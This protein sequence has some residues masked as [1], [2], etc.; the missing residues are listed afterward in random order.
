MWFNQKRYF[1]IV[2]AL[3]VMLV[4][5]YV[6]G[7]FVDVTRDAGKYASVAREVYE[8][9]D[10][11][12][13]RVHGEPYDQKPPM[14]FWLSALSFYIFGLS[15]F[16]FK[17]PL[18]FTGLLGIYSTYRLGK[19]L[20][21]VR[22]GMTAAMMLAA[23]QVYFLYYMDIHTDSVLQPFVTFALWQLYE[24]IKKNKNVH[25]I[26]GFSGI[27]CAMLTKG[28]VGALVPAFAVLG[29]LVFTRQY[30]RLL[31]IRW[32]LGA[33][34]ALILI[35]PALAGLYNQFGWEGIR[36]YFWTN[37]AGRLTGQLGAHRPDYFFYVH[38]LLYLFFP[39]MLLLFVSAGFEFRSLI[40]RRFRGREFYIFPG[41]WLFFL[42]LTLS[43]G[44]LPNYIFVLMPLFSLLTA[45]YAM[46]ATGGR[47]PSL[48]RL[49]LRMQAVSVVLGSL[50]V[51]VIIFWLFPVVKAVMFLPAIV[52]VFVIGFALNKRNTD[53]VRLFLPSLAVAIVLNLYIN[54]H[55]APLIFSAQ[56]SVKAAAIFN[57]ESGP[58]DKI[59]NYN[60]ESH[61]LFFYAVRPA[62]KVINDVTVIRLMQEPGNWVLTERKVVE[63]LEGDYPEPEI[64][65]LEHVWLNKLSLKYLNPRT[66]SQATDTL[67][68]MRSTAVGR[69]K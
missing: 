53:K 23:S 6:A 34:L 4:A 60:Y 29:H 14:L 44:K 67:F 24:F 51:A 11:I 37:N 68:L 10:F 39:W 19:S 1:L 49:F 7:L 15:N 59:H 8:S 12:N 65:P 55:V 64:I 48:F 36:F 46:L 54:M 9:G 5:A 28:P 40:K 13:L 47:R 32:Y 45:K 58:G 69:N 35:L 61:E 16:A 41:T 33:L 2:P 22:V 26:L 52:M 27:G 56:A 21:N 3:L 25:L 38:N 30:E 20:Y 43:K 63:R 66:R 42:I 50:L 62:V 31:D 18:L 57:A 17:L